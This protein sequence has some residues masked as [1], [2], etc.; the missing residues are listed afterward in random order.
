MLL[1]YFTYEELCEL[2]Q[3]VIEWHLM[4]KDAQS[5]EKGLVEATE[6]EESDSCK[7]FKI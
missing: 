3:K 4:K 2:K 5:V 1:E 6:K 7:Y